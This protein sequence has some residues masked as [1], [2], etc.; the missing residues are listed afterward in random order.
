MNNYPDYVH[1]EMI[2]YY[3]SELINIGECKDI[4]GKLIFDERMSFVW[5]ALS[6]RAN[7]K[8]MPYFFFA[9]LTEKIE[10]LNK[11]P[12]EWDLI[13]HRNKMAKL[14][15]ISE[16]SRLLSLEIEGTPVDISVT[17]FM[18]HRVFVRSFQD[19]WEGND[20]LKMMNFTLE[21]YCSEGN[22]FYF[23]KTENDLGISNVWSSVGVNGPHVS[24]VLDSLSRKAAEYSPA[25]VIKRKGDNPEKTYFVRSL[26]DF[27]KD[28]FGESLY[29]ITAVISSIFLNIEIDIETVVSIT[30]SGK[31]LA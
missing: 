7:S 31:P 16:L 2:R 30:K 8:E 22:G 20:R 24:S 4:A 14:K 18:N 6:K 12:C 3:E 26:S 1:D 29:N 10:L 13:T 23:D 15:R 19:K 27:F 11:G 9:S 25:S 21:K 28:F 5:S 17:S